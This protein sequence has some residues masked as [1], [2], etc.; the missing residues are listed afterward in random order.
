MERHEPLKTFLTL[1]EQKQNN[2]IKVFKQI[3]PEA[4][5]DMFV[6]NH[7][8]TD[9]GAIGEIPDTIKNGF[10]TMPSGFSTV[11]ALLFGLMIDLLPIL[12]GLLAFVAGEKRRN[13]D[14]DDYLVHRS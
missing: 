14:D 6:E 12:F 1:V 4:K 8:N 2:L 13:D 10:V 11:Y 3:N 7:I 9:N 5:N